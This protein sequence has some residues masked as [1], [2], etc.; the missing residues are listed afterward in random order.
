MKIVIRRITKGDS[1]EW[2]KMRKGIWP[3]APDEYL[4]FDMVDILA[5]DQD[6]VFFALVDGKP[7]GMLEARLREY[8]EGCE[9]GPVG[10]IEGWFVYPEIRGKG[11]AGALSQAAEDWARGK[12]CTEMASDTW[13]DNEAGI[14]AHLKLGYIE[15]E[16]LVHFVKQL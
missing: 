16:R 6:A 11:V 8:G 10:Y 2:F 1:H 4:N 5:S 9:T 14:R 3:D 12:G 7:V 15:A 13:L